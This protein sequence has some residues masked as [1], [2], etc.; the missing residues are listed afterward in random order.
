MINI[1]SLSANAIRIE[2]KDEGPGISESDQKMLFIKFQKLTAQPTAGEQSSGLGLSIV[3]KYIDA[4]HG[5]IWCKSELEKGTS[6]FVEF[7]LI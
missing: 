6:F 2:V 3:K 1:T 7:A 5:K 4:M